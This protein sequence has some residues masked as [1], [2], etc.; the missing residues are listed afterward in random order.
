M[1]SVLA[2]QPA[3]EEEAEVFTPRLV[4]FAQ[5]FVRD[6]G[7]R[8]VDRFPDSGGQA[9]ARFGQGTGHREQHVVTEDRG[10]GGGCVGQRRGSV[11]AVEGRPVVDQPGLAVPGQ[12]V[13]IARGAVDVGDQGVEEDDVGGQIRSKSSSG[14]RAKG[15]DPGRKSMPRLIPGLASIS[16]WISGSGSA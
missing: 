7:E 5:P 1:K 10:G 4:I 8:G 9:F 13:R 6:Q 16:S 12:Q 11:L 3:F 2:R 15:R 14:D